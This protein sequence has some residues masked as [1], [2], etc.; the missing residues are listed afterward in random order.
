MNQYTSSYKVRLAD[1]D[2]A[3]LL[4]FSKIYDYAHACYEDY[5]QHNKL[6]LSDILKQGEYLLPIISSSAEY[7]KAMILGQT[8]NIALSVEKVST[9]AFTLAYEFSDQQGK[10][11][12]T[13]QT[14]HVS[15]S[16]HSKSKIALPKNLI[17]VLT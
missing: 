8:I 9:S 16:T 14:V 1:T 7:K 11:L 5:M 4:F 10:L 12:A 3:G 6:D 13:V 2:A 15:I 17:K